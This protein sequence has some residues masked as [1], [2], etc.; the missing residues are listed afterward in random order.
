M[1]GLA[2][3]MR[4]RGGAVSGCDN[5]IS[6]TTRSL[7]EHGIAVYE[8]HSPEHV[9]GAAAVV[10][11]S[12]VPAAH[13]E[14]ETARIRGLPVMKRSQ[15]L[16]DLVNQGSLVAIS[17]THGKTTTSALTAL[18]LEASGLDPTALVGG[19]VL[20]WGGNARIGGSANYVVEADE[21]DRSFLTL[22]PDHA[23]V[24][25]VEQ[26]HLDTYGTFAEMEAAFDEFVGRVP[27]G[28]RVIACVDDAGAR[29]RLQGVGD[30]GLGYGTSDDA[31]LQA[32][33]IVQE[34]DRTRFSVRWRGEPQGEFDLALRGQHNV[35]NALAVIGVMLSLGLEPQAATGALAGFAGV[36]RRFQ[37]IGSAGGIA[38]ID[39]YAHH[40]TEVSA[41]LETARQAFG[42]RRLVVAFQPHLYSRTQ[43]FARQFGQS[44]NRADLV[45][46]TD[47]YPAR[48][49]PI[50]GVTA[51]LVVD[52]ARDVIGDERVRF[53]PDLAALT[54]AVKR[55][56]EA[57]DVFITL[58]A[59]DV[60][61]VAHAI[62]EELEA[63]DVDE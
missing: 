9:E 57:G 17:G 62:S 51:Q 1:A 52:A 20:A 58:G 5:E 48:E 33:S 3:L 50:P 53:V 10:H 24:T 44:L 28:G 27:T 13:P 60:G 14:L 18:A 12:A 40:P 59:G 32:D 36:E 4:A 63:S 61:S 22:W 55:E 41:T 42:T 26:E 15:A 30:R 54:E 2:L 16:G 23:V 45:F 35:R 39:D 38:V 34:A 21:Y 8:G 47:I 43:A 6:Q 46:V 56:L 37:P 29:R 25:S 7:E 11:T 19:R 49:K 31:E